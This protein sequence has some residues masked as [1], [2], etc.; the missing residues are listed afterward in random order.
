M[1]GIVVDLEGKLNHHQDETV[2]ELEEKLKHHQDKTVAELK[3]GQELPMNMLEG[4]RDA[5]SEAIEN[6]DHLI[7]VTETPQKHVEEQLAATQK[8]VEE[9]LQQVKDHVK[10]MVREELREL[11]A[12]ECIADLD[13]QAL[14]LEL[15]QELTDGEEGRLSRSKSHSVHFTLPEGTEKFTCCRCGQKRHLSVGRLMQVKDK[16]REAGTNTESEN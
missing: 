16:S 2:M 8:Q 11:S 3:S 5:V 15:P 9:Q 10:K 1:Q 6:Q 4:P 13:A 7:S 14:K 12:G